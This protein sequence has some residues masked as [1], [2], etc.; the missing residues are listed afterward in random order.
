MIPGLYETYI[1]EKLAS[2]LCS[3]VLDAEPTILKAYD[4]RATMQTI[5]HPHKSMVGYFTYYNIFSWENPIVKE[6]TEK[7]VQSIDEYEQLFGKKHNA[8]YGKCWAPVLRTNEY[9]PPHKHTFEGDSCM[10]ISGH[11]TLQAINTK[12]YYEHDNE[13]HFR[14][15]APGQL[16]LLPSNILHWTDANP[17]DE[18][19]VTIA[20]DIRPDPEVGRYP[21]A[22]PVRLR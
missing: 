20:F 5:G 14:I 7:V 13:S 17:V 15:N 4:G 2:E 8:L 9:I 10:Y 16:S 11:A 3:V 21:F 19:R 22:P 6:F 18:V 12:T 1:G